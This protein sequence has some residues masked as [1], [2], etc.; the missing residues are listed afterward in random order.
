M[1]PSAWIGGFFLVFALAIVG[2]G[3]SVTPAS[4]EKEID[5]L[6]NEAPNIKDEASSKAFQQ[7]LEAI[8]KKIETLPKDKQPELYGK[9]MAA[10]MAAAFKGLRI[11]MPG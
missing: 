6:K 9:L 4:V 8:S 10:S 1:R 11:D 5:A 2:C 3:G 7:K